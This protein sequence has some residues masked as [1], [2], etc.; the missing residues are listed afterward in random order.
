MKTTIIGWLKKPWIWAGV[1]LALAL[2]WLRTITARGPRMLPPPPPPGADLR[3]KAKTHDAE[4]DK[5]KADAL[6]EA[7][8]RLSNPAPTTADVA[9]LQA[10][11]D[12]FRR[13]R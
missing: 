8:A 4:A 6:A 2:G 10:D 1:A 13:T 12:K 9:E 7:N 3:A 5:V 11:L